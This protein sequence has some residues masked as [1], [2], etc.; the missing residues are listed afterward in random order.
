MDGRVR[1]VGLEAGEEKEEDGCVLE[2]VVERSGNR[3]DEDWI[4][5]G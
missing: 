3:L 5:N 1:E 4:V 2:E